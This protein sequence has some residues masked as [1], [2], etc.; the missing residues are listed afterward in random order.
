MS[1]EFGA[2]HGKFTCQN[3]AN[4]ALIRVPEEPPIIVL[5][6]A[7]LTNAILTI[8]ILKIDILTIA[9]L[10]IVLTTCLVTKF[11]QHRQVGKVKNPATDSQLIYWLFIGFSN[12]L[13]RLR[14]PCDVSRVELKPV[15]VA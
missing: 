12:P 5:T 10:T 13:V 1:A 7:D 8:A 11:E 14:V 4:K 9:F 2:C 15:L 6:T 3:C